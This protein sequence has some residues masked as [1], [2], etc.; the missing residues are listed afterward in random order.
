MSSGVKEANIIEA[1]TLF[2]FQLLS[3]MSTL[4][5]ILMMYKKSS[6]H[7]S[8]FTLACIISNHVSS[9]I[10]LSKTAKKIFEASL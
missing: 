6:L 7:V 10:L 8:I 5:S 1:N 2:C 4:F 3:K 9:K